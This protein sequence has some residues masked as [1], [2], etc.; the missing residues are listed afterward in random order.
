MKLALTEGNASLAAWEEYRLAF[1]DF[2][3]SVQN[4]QRV[5]ERPNPNYGAIGQ[6]IL[7]SERA[8]DIR[9]LPQCARSAAFADCRSRCGCQCPLRV[10]GGYDRASSRDCRITVES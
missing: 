4:V 2:A 9:T 10:A 7:E 5:M 6:A 3:R 1:R 8:R